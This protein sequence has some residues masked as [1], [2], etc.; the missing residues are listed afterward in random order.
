[1]YLNARLQ[2]TSTQTMKRVQP[3]WTSTT[4]PVSEQRN[5]KAM[6]TAKG[7]TMLMR[8]VSTNPI[9]PRRATQ[10]LEKQAPTP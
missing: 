8:N 10:R 5:C 6:K 4:L 3:G 7:L 9:A 2:K 1:M